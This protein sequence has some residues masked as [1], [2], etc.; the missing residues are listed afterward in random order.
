MLVQVL[1]KPYA[2][3]ELSEEELSEL[4]LS[5]EELSAAEEAEEVSS[6]WLEE[7]VSP[8]EASSGKGVPSSRRAPSANKA[9]WVAG[10]AMP[11]A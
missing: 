7:L 8:A 6:A 9:A 4:V 5:S 10:S 11:V 2:A 3:V 1:R